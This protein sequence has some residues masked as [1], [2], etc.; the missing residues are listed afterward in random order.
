MPVS[1]LWASDDT[2]YLSGTDILLV[3]ERLSVKVCK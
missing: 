3:I 1:E 2:C